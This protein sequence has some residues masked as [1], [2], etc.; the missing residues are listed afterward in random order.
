MRDLLQP[1]LYGV[2]ATVLLSTQLLST[3]VMA[4]SV[5]QNLSENSLQTDAQKNVSSNLQNKIPNN[6][7]TNLRTFVLPEIYVKHQA[8]LELEKQH[9]IVTRTVLDQAS[10]EDLKTMLR[11]ETG[12]EV[13][14]QS[15]L[16]NG[17]LNIRGISEDRVLTMVDGLGLPDAFKDNFWYGGGGNREKNGM[18][19]GQN[20]VEP[21]TV[22]S[23]NIVKGPF[24]ALFGS[25]AIGGAVNMRTAEAEDFLLNDK[26]WGVFQKTA[27]NSG[28]KGWS[29]TTGIAGVTDQLSG[30]L[31]YSHRDYAEAQTAGPQANKQNNKSNNILAKGKMTWDVHQLS[32]TAENFKREVHSQDLLSENSFDDTESERTRLSLEYQYT[33]ATDGKLSWIK[34]GADYQDLSS[35]MLQRESAPPYINRHLQGYDQTLNRVYVQGAWNFVAKGQH[36]LIAGTEYKEVDTSTRRHRADYDLQGVPR[37]TIDE[38]LYYP[39][40]TKQVWSAY[41]RDRWA[42]NHGLSITSGLRYTNEKTQPDAADFSRLKNQANQNFETLI[43]ARSFDEVTPSLTLSQALNKENQLFV[44]YARGFKTPQYDANGAA[45]HSVSGGTIQYYTVPNLE[46]KPEESENLEFG[47]LYA[48]EKLQTQITGFYNNYKNFIEEAQIVK[49]YSPNGRPTIDNPLVMELSA[50]NLDRVETYGVEVRG[51]YAL[52]PELKMNSS[53]FWMR[54]INKADGSHINTE[55]PL[56][57]RLGMEYQQE[58]WGV[59]ANWIIS[60]DKSDYATAQASTPKTPGYGLID[61]GGFWQANQHARLNLN[62]HNVLDKKYWLANDMLWLNTTGQM[63]HKDHYS[64]TGRAVSA[65]LELKF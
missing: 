1:A 41:I 5:P 2:C 18:T 55:L 52:T 28:N 64:Q 14:A 11:Y 42:F 48:D 60:D 38:Q 34:M 61:L 62:I 56:K 24:D 32:A 65:N 9:K 44:S 4:E 31:M 39:A 8:D 19:F 16:S 53:I 54:G 15:G 23:I 7:Q 12:V 50:I 36:H 51:Q 25:D 58:D 47:W 37:G 30:L 22:Q 26:N 27:A 40:N 43:K 17:N 46:L 45:S 20:L 6:T 35:E 63:Q 10:A 13:E 33:P 49:T 59:N 29:S 21:D 3:Q 57:A